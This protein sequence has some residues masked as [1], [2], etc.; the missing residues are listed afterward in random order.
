MKLYR[1]QVVFISLMVVA[2]VGGVILPVVLPERFLYDASMIVL[3]RYNESGWLGSYPF[4]MTFY[5]ITALG[6]LPYS[7]I[8]LIQ[9]PLLFWTIG[10]L[11]IPRN[12][13][14]LTIRNL[15]VYALLLLMAVFVSY[16]SKEFINIICIAIISGVLISKKGLVTKILVSTLLFLIFA[17]FFRP[18]Y[19][20]IPIIAFVLFSLNFISLKSKAATNIF[21]GILIAVFLSLSY[22]VIKGEYISEGSRAKLNEQRLANNNENADTM[23]VSPVPVD[24]AVGESISIFYGFFTVN[25]PLNGLRFWYKPQVVAFLLLQV[26]LFLLLFIYYSRVLKNKRNRHAQWIFNLLFAYFIIQ[27]VFEPDL[28]SAIRHK[29]GVLPLI[30]IAIYYDQ[31]FVNKR[32]KQIHRN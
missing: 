26:I 22:G 30:W 16:P 6:T 9:L 32:V 20:A 7:L 8:G 17:L 14:K 1:G 29:I 11:G 15:I 10:L 23:I 5:K 24:N 28:G 21:S 19:A 3:D 2:T 12:F 13:Y 31:A 27:G 18:Y 4:T 25:L